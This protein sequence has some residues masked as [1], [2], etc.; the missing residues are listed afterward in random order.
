MR[1]FSLCD[2][3]WG[4]IRDFVKAWFFIEIGWYI[5]PEWQKIKKVQKRMGV[6]NRKN[7][8]L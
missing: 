6:F 4:D 1:W 8:P 5:I 7:L 3:G 2:S